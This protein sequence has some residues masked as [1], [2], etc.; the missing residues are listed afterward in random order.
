MISKG[1]DPMK[2]TRQEVLDLFTYIESCAPNDFP[3]ED[4]ANLVEVFDELY[5]GIAECAPK[6]ASEE[7]LRY[8]QLGQREIDEAF[9]RY[10]SGDSVGGAQALSRARSRF[11][12]G[13]RGKVPRVAFVSGDKGLVPVDDTPLP[14]VAEPAILSVKTR[15]NS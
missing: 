12:H 3:E 9:S 10:K 5:S 15:N 8:L 13:W 14:T 2:F 4:E 1:G 11:E 7:V 6:R